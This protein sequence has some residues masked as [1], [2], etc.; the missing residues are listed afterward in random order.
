[1]RAL[2]TG[3]A[4]FI[5]SH[6][7][8]RLM[9]EGYYVTVIDNF[10]SGTIENIKQW[11][12]HPQFKLIRGDLRNPETILQA[13]KNVDV[14]FH[15]AAN[16][17]VRVGSQNPKVIYENN[18]AATFNLLE[19]MRKN[20]VKHLIFTSSSTVY[21]EAKIIPTPEN[22]A[23]LAPIS[24]YGASKLACE[25]LITAYAHTFKIKSLILRLAN[26]VGA[27][28]NHGVIYDF[29]NK[30]KRNPKKLEILGDGTQQKS[31][32]HVKDCT[33]AIIHLNEVFTKEDKL[34]DIYN[35]GSEDW[36]TV[37]EIADIIVEELGLKNVEYHFTGGV[38]G[39][40]GWPGDVKIM[41]LDIT[42]AKSKGWKP[43]TNSRETVKQATK[44]LLNHTN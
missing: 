44:E 18:V 41:L 37:K 21:G 7:V 23:P 16:P 25:A 29:I 13:I 10:S 3:G 19:A 32:L 40:R 20:N 5:G 14:V 11:L 38:D 12:D 9:K 28:S 24:I 6:L 33:N 34:H 42:K 27:R 36:I 30:L 31:Y 43:A 15:L 2:V 4:G 1:M 17:E 35:I 22:Y 8:D 39:G 26:I